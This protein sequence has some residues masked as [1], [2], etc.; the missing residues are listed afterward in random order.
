MKTIVSILVSAALAL[1]MG[2]SPSQAAE[3]KPIAALTVA[4]Y[5]DLVGDVN[6]VGSLVDRPEMGTGLEGFLAI[7]TQGKGLAGIDKTRNWGLIVQASNEK[8]VTAYGFLPVT[9]FKEA[10]GLLKLYFKVSAAGDAFKLT[11]KDDKG[12]GGYVKQ[13]GDWALFAQ[14]AE[15]LA[16]GDANPTALLGNLKKEYIVAGRVFL[17]NVPQELREKILN[18]VKANFQKDSAQHGDESSEAFASRKKLIG[19]METYVPR[20]LGELDQVIFGWG[21]NR[22]T[23][24]AFVDVSVIAKPG[25]TTAEEMGLAATATT[26][27][28]GFRD[29]AAALNV[30]W[31]GT[32]PAPKQEIAGSV[33]EIARGN[34]LA[35]I[36]KKTDQSESARTAGKAVANGAADLL[37]KI[38][39]SG[40]VDGVASVQVGPDAATGLLAGYIA[41]GALLDKILHTAAKALLDEHPELSQFIALDA[42]KSGSINIHKISIPLPAGSDDNQKLIKMVGEKLDI[43]IGVGKE[44][45]YL[46]AGRD[47]MARL[48]K[49]VDASAQAGSKAVLPLEASVGAQ[50][51]ATFVAAVG[52]PDEQPKAALAESELKKTPGK[53]HVLLT[54]RPITNGVRVR[55][56]IEQGLLRLVGRL[57]AMAA[58]GQ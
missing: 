35:E 19:Q 14:K 25:T 12:E 27:F 9:D 52:K 23:E 33:V 16:Q 1:G 21:L 18:Q 53:D 4:S 42:E 8:D 43:I 17:A 15:V 46:A 13:Q 28:S 49:A 50:S 2:L 7:V 6:F 30:A 51:V 57:A 37:Q 32:M 45:A 40:R 3:T 48:K 5:N 41:D 44:D 58:Q 24:K 22:T 31:A 10:L 34:I 26:M 56:E 38:V 29:P 39:K 20:V 54:V 36:A 55:L 11:P 47:A